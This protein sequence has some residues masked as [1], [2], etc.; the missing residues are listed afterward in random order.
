MRISDW[1]SDVCSSDLAEAV[2]VAVE[3]DAQVGLE[4]RD[5]VD[6]VLEVAWFA[7]VGMVVGEIAVDLAEQRDDFRA[8]RLQHARADVAGHAVAGI[9]SSEE[10]RVGKEWVSPCRLR[11]S[12]LR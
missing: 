5:R 1:S 12:P 6:Q 9:D 10:R 4:A 11:W 8:D 2:A 7:R 3:G